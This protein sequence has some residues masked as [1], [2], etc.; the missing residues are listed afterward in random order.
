MFEKME[1]RYGNEMTTSYESSYGGEIWGWGD[2]GLS[3]NTE[4][5]CF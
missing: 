4:G 1:V 5:T 3:R 2:K